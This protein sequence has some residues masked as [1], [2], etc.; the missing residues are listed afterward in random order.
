MDTSAII[1]ALIGCYI[2]GYFFGWQF[3]A[4]KRLFEQI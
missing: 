4:G 3:L 1:A 2:A